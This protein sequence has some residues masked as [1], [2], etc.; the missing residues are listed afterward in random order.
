MEIRVLYF[1]K[2]ADDAG[3]REQD[4]S[5]PD[6]ATLKDLRIHLAGAF[7]RDFLHYGFAINEEWARDEHVLQEGDEVAVLPPVSGGSALASITRD[8][9]AWEDLTRSLSH[10][11]S[12]S[13]LLF[14]GTV[15]DRFEGRPTGALEYEGYE[16][17]AL[18][19]LEKIAREAESACPGTR[20]AVV[21]RLGRLELEEV[22]VAIAVSS[23][24]R[25][26]A[27]TACRQV[28]E[29]IKR[30][31]PIWKREIGPDGEYWHIE[32]GVGP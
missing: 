9:I 6:H 29:E 8:P 19:E 25:A 21:H 28:I 23:P 5:L 10:P 15:R 14:L 16:P 7:G 12:G 4:L 11:G 26:D 3:S 18:K 13:T 27:F 31:L 17:M 22:S 30:R 24:H 20:I 32:G 1:A 2:A